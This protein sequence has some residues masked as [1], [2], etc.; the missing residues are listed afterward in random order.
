MENNYKKIIFLPLMVSLSISFLSSSSSSNIYTSNSLNQ[1]FS[2]NPILQL[3]INNKNNVYNFW[4]KAINTSYKN[5]FSANF[6][7]NNK[8]D[9][10]NLINNQQVSFPGYGPGDDSPSNSLDL[11]SY[12]NE[13]TDNN[14]LNP[15]S[16]NSEF[17]GYFIA[18]RTDIFGLSFGLT[19]DLTYSINTR[20]AN[21]LASNGYSYIISLGSNDLNYSDSISSQDNANTLP[22][23]IHG[24][25]SSANFKTPSKNDFPY[26]QL[27][28]LGLRNPIDDNGANSS[29]PDPSSSPNYSQNN[30]ILKTFNHDISNTSSILTEPNRPNQYLERPFEV[31][32][33]GITYKIISYISNLD[34]TDVIITEYT[35]SN[36]PNIYL[37]VDRLFNYSR[38]FNNENYFINNGYMFARAMFP[39]WYPEGYVSP[40]GNAYQYGNMWYNFIENGVFPSTFDPQNVANPSYTALENVVHRTIY[41]A[42]NISNKIKNFLQYNPNNYDSWGTILLKNN[43]NVT[44]YNPAVSPSTKKLFNLQELPNGVNPREAQT[45]DNIP[46]IS[47]ST[48]TKRNDND[49]S[50]LTVRGPS[51]YFGSPNSKNP[52]SYLNFAG[53]KFYT[54]AVG[55]DIFN[56]KPFLDFSTTSADSGTSVSGESSFVYS[57]Y[58]QNSIY[59]DLPKINRGIFDLP[60]NN[61]PFVF[62]VWGIVLIS[63]FG[64]LLLSGILYFV[65][66]RKV[67]EKW[68]A[69]QSKIKKFDK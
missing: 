61:T 58:L 10:H 12:T 50:F 24:N 30:N 44:Q 52:N 65:W 20:S 2:N 25:Q 37:M 6:V 41:K 33:N 60:N 26:F 19:G 68:K 51:K 32:H 14:N 46:N 48:L 29:P 36:D 43:V 69:S 9:F 1:D 64:F 47:L 55:N 66:K 31:S 16:P 53:Y 45:Y 57:Q 34:N 42:P 67:I 40:S 35:K 21:G 28:M 3:N 38:K 27:W 39:Y 18:G 8:I 49:Y 7:Q 5:D 23:Y 63:I 62:P 15:P 17:N 11:F 13:L 54:A 56:N 22:F 4:N 59:N